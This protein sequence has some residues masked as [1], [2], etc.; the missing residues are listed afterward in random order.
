MSARTSHDFPAL[1]RKLMRDELR[2]IWKRHMFVRSGL[3][4]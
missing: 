2:L 1:G 3:N 4:L